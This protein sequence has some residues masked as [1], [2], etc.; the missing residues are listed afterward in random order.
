MRKS[1]D[2]INRLTSP[3]QCQPKTASS[4]VLPGIDMTTY[5]LINMNGVII[6]VISVSV[7]TAAV[8]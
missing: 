2:V 4:K 7:I 8:D 1:D 5:L 6:S 3:V